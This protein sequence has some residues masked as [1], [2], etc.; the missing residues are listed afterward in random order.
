MDDYIVNLR[1]LS[2]RHIGA[3]AAKDAPDLLALDWRTVNWYDSLWLFELEGIKASGYP[4]VLEADA[5][6]RYATTEKFSKWASGVM[7]NSAHRNR[8][9]WS[10]WWRRLPGPAVEIDPRY[11]AFRTIHDWIILCSR[12]LSA[13]K[14][15]R[16]DFNS[17]GPALSD[18][19][20]GPFTQP[21]RTVDDSGEPVGLLCGNPRERLSGG[22]RA[23]RWDPAFAALEWRQVESLWDALY[24]FHWR[25]LMLPMELR[26]GALCDQ[27]DPR[28]SNL[29]LLTAESFA[30]YVADVL[31]SEDR[32]QSRAWRQ[33]PVG[34]V[35]QD[36]RFIAHKCGF[37]SQ[38]ILHVARDANES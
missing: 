34:E 9:S 1:T 12:I 27:G 14:D 21:I 4:D 13:K 30:R 25:G 31:V 36:P 2:Q 17:L 19:R 7:F 11:V 32:S 33:R 10:I 29:E 22:R 5:A 37:D 15:D 18:A 35:L 38:M 3:D 8:T 26:Y 24:Y 28:L 6:I 20:L 16:D 23:S